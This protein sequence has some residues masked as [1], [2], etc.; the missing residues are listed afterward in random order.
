MN[1]HCGHRTNGSYEQKLGQ[2]N[3]SCAAGSTAPFHVAQHWWTGG[4]A[5]LEMLAWFTV[6]VTEKVWKSMRVLC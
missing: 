4:Q 2:D 5:G 1:L 3:W 6:M